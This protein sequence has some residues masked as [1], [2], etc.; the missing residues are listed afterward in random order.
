[1]DEVVVT[2]KK[3][4]IK[5]N[6]NAAMICA[7]SFSVEETK[8]FPASI[9]D[10]GRM[11]LSFAGVTTSNDETNEIVIRGNAPNFLLWRIEGMEVPNPNHFSEEGY[12]SGAV[13][14]LNTNMLDRSDFLTGAFPAE[15]G[16]A[17]SGVFDIKLRNGNAKKKEYAFQL[18]VMG[19]DLTAEG[20]IKKGYNGSYLIN[21]RYS[22][23]GILDKVIDFGEDFGAPI[24]QD[25]SF[26]I[27]LPSG[28]RLVVS[29]WGIMGT[30]ESNTAQSESDTLI[31]DDFL[32]SKTYMSG[33][34]YSYFFKD[35]SKL[36]A[37]V[38]FS[39]NSSDYIYEETNLVENIYE[40]DSGIEL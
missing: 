28:K 1:M 11:A 27:N 12:S 29:L 31:F 7:R 8:R 13:S 14:I 16:N 25:L 32:T 33:A 26:K 38:S 15:Y 39:G 21:Y 2:A 34:N 35:K 9:S 37:K 30:S 23:L 5:P 3:D 22:T 6:N 24:F 36:E 20:P 40:A 17:M 10:P 19:T 4:N 18:G